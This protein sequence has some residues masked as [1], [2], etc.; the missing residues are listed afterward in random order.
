M[1]QQKNI[2]MDCLKVPDEQAALELAESFMKMDQRVP[3]T[4]SGSVL[5]PSPASSPSTS[6]HTLFLTLE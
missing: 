1:S 2:A 6:T 3:I 4:S 5:I